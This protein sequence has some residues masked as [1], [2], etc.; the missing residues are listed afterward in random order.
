MESVKPRIDSMSLLDSLGYSYYYFDEE[1]EYPEIAEIR[2]EDILPE[3]VSS[4]SRKT[5]ELVGKNLYRHQYEAYDLLRNGSN[6]ILKSG[7]GSGKTE[8]WFL[9]TAKHR[10]KTLSIYPT[11]ALAYDQLGRLS[12]YCSDLNMKIVI[13]DALKKTELISKYGLRE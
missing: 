9:Y 10:V 1:G 11:L 8:A 6:I 2:F 3:I 4:R 13:L 5:Q 7:T 12:Q